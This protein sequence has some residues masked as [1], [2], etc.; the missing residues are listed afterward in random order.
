MLMSWME[1][2]SKGLEREHHEEALSQAVLNR[3]NGCIWDPNFSVY[4]GCIHAS[5]GIQQGDH[6]SPFIFQL[7]VKSLVLFS[8]LSI[9]MDFESFLVGK[10]KFT[11]QFYNFLNFKN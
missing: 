11:S 1:N 10:T 9:R 2:S 4:I 8:L 3:T 7:L 5:R 6:L